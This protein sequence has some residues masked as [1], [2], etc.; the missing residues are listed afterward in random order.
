MCGINI[1][2]HVHIFYVP[3]FMSMLNERLKNVSAIVADD[4]D[5]MWHISHIWLIVLTVEEDM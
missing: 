5:E 4:E 3:G 1:F 2:L